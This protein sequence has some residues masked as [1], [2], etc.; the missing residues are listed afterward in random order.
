[1]LA[2]PFLR[3]AGYQQTDLNTPGPLLAAAV[4]VVLAGAWNGMGNFT[5]SCGTYD[6]AIGPNLTPLMRVGRL[7]LETDRAVGDEFILGRGGH[8]E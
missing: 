1:M 3:P 5:A 4:L 6:I 8:Y 2:R 7:R